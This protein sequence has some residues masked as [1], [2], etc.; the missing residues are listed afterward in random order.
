MNEAVRTY[1]A[2]IDR[3]GAKTSR[4]TL[5]PEAAGETPRDG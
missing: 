4:R 1:L 3:R 2:E 5:G